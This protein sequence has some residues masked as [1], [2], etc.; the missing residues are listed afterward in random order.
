MVVEIGKDSLATLQS[1]SGTISQAFCALPCKKSTFSKDVY[2]LSPLRESVS[3]L[4][5]LPQ[6]LLEFLI[7]LSPLWNVGSPRF[8]T[9]KKHERSV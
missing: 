2:K 6:Y 4:K 5:L 8:V 7:F 3:A 1:N 9:S